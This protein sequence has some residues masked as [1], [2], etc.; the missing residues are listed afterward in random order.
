MLDS[1]KKAVLAGIG[2]AVVTKD[3]VQS[4][5]DELVRQGKLSAEDAR[6]T[7]E[8]IATDGRREFDDASGKVQKKLHD[9][10][11]HSDRKSQARI[12]ALEARLRDL[13]TRHAKAASP[14][15]TRRAPPQK[16]KRATKS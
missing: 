9:L 13:E 16:T 11:N 6:T 5:L 3:K 15:T 12:D 8:R 1:I 4:S 2:A 14:K 7:A 10:L